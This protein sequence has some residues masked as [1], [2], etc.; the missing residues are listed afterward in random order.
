MERLRQRILLIGWEFFNL[1][2]RLSKEFSH[3]STAV[4]I[5]I[6]TAS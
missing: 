6:S 3:S 2:D 5:A 1:G 4:N